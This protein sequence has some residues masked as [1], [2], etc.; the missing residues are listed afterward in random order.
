LAPSDSH[1]F[2]PA[3]HA[4]RRPFLLVRNRIAAAF[5]AWFAERGFIE[6]DCAALAFSPG[7]EA[8]LHGFATEL[9]QPDGS[10]ERRYLHTSP[11]F[12]MKK[13]LAAG[14]P[15]LWQLARCFRNSERSATHHPEFAML[16]WYRAEADYGALMQDCEALLKHV[17]RECGVERLRWGGKAAD[18][19][20]PFERLSVAEAFARYC[21]FDLL[22]CCPDPRDPGAE[23]KALDRLAAA[24]RALNM[25]PH[26]G[27]R[28]DDYFFRLFFEHVEGKLGVGRPTIL[29]D[30]PVHMAALSRPKPGDPRLAE[31][32]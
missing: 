18:P 20:A 27:D 9:I 15:R 7:N 6:V 13:L 29:Y 4:D 30:Y 1:W 22:A 8:H 3:R 21:G 25:V 23:A 24:S 10:T 14:V 31:R 17:A 26:E 5:R 2:S 32:F 11:E 12:A 19:A 28:W 16:E